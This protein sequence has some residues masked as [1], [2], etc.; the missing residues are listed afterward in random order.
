MTTS[1]NR[2]VLPP[3]RSWPP[4]PTLT[5][6]VFEL[7]EWPGPKWLL[8][9]DGTDDRGG[10]RQVHLAYGDALTRE[11]VS[12]VVTFAKRPAEDDGDGGVSATDLPHVGDYAVLHLLER[13]P[14]PPT[15]EARRAWEVE[16]FQFST[17]EIEPPAWSPIFVEL[18]QT[19]CA[20][21]RIDIDNGWAICVDAGDVFLAVYSAGTLAS[22]LALQPVVDFVNYPMPSDADHPND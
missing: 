20:G 21:H 16:R 1:E 19:Q 8:G 14:Q 2:L 11:I 4:P 10:L 3:V 7:K 15:E 17:G 5:V 12:G 18:Q 13:L 6:P 9:Y 22:Q